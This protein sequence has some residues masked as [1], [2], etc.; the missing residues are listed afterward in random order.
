MTRLKFYLSVLFAFALLRVICGP[1]NAS[2]VYYLGNPGSDS[3]SPTQAQSPSTPW[4]SLQHA[5]NNVSCGDTI[6]V[7]ANGNSVPGDATL[8]YFSNCG[9]VTT[10]QSAALSLFQPI[11]YRTNPTADGPNYGKL[12]FTSGPIQTVPKVYTLNFYFGYSAISYNLSTNTVTIMGSNGLTNGGSAT[13]G[14]GTQIE[15]E[16]DSTSTNNYEAS[17]IYPTISIPSGL[18]PGTHYYL[19]TCSGCGAQNTTFQLST[20]PGGSAVAFGTCG[21]Y[22]STT[23]STLPSGACSNAKYMEYDTANSTNYICYGGVWAATGVEP[24]NVGVPAQINTSNSTVWISQNWGSGSL[25]NGDAVTFSTSGLQ[26]FGTLPAP[27]QLDTPYYVVSLSG[28]IFKLAALPGGSPITLT[29]VGTGMINLATSAIAS[30]WALRGLELYPNGTNVP[31]GLV[32]MGSGTETSILGMASHFEIDRSYLHDNPPTQGVVHAVIDNGTFI[33]IHDSWIIGADTSEGAEGQAISGCMSLGPTTV[34]NNFLEADSEV[35]LYG[36]CGSGYGKANIFKLFQSNFFFKPPSWKILTGTVPVSGPC[37]YD[38]T[39]PTHPGG[40]WWKNTS[41]GQAYQCGSNG[42]WATT[43][44]PFPTVSHEIKDMA[45]YK[46]GRYFTYVGNLFK[47]SIAQDQSGQL[48]N[49]SMGIGRGGGGPGSGSDHITIMH[50]A[51]YNALVFSNRN[52]ICNET[53]NAECDNQPGVHRAIN[54]LMVVNTLTC[55]V[56]FPTT[57]TQSGSNTIV[58]ADA[59]GVEMSDTFGPP[60]AV[61]GVGIPATTQISGISGTTI[62][63]NNPV[64]ITGTINVYFSTGCGFQSGNQAFVGGFAPNFTDDLWRHNTVWTQEIYPFATSGWSPIF[65]PPPNNGSCPYSPLPADKVV[66]LDSIMP[67]DLEGQCGEGGLAL[68]GQYSNSTFSHNVFR[69]AVGSYA[70]AGASNCFTVSNCATPSTSGAFPALNSSIGYVSATG[71]NPLNYGLT[72]SSPYSA[73]NGSA[74]FVATDGSDVGADVQTIAMHQWGAQNGKP[75]PSVNVAPGSV[76]AI[77]TF[78]AP[79]LGAC[80]ALLYPGTGPHNGTPLSTTTDTI[81]SGLSKEIDLLSLTAS[82]QY[83]FVVTCAG[84]A[85]W[86]VVGSFATNAAAAASKTWQISNASGLTW[87]KSSSPSMSSPTS[88]GSGSTV[89]ATVSAGGLTYV[90]PLCSSG[91]YCGVQ[92]VNAP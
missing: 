44:S 81:T 62:T 87:Y 74:S 23:V 73:A 83:Q 15:F 16:V 48:F 75:V 6:M 43:A 31:Y 24:I 78:Q 1:L 18:T 33:N 58:V 55:G 39:D 49:N 30:G 12:T 17:G 34:T 90:S 2:T 51:G 42:L 59:S 61:S 19:I 10:V 63:L 82:T 65:A 21:A 28:G 67:K 91:A 47:N 80:T 84:D 36:G 72:S 57:A 76:N 46:N 38:S 68:V 54:N 40:E 88:I 86:I 66:M 20:T 69:G 53:S 85:T 50:N 11:G 35:A 14:N 26:L 22:C 25:S 64:S 9:L 70:S 5:V 77:L 13:F 7:I 3:N 4:A 37:L 27:L 32:W 89:Q 92:G 52:S 41:S 45:E 71:M 60:T 56:T 29:S 79:A 8:P